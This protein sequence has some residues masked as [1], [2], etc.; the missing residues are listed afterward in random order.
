MAEGRSRRRGVVRSSLALLP[1]AICEMSWTH[2]GRAVC[3][4]L[5]PGPTAGVPGATMPPGRVSPQPPHFCCSTTSQ[6]Q[7]VQ[8]NQGSWPPVTG[9]HGSGAGGGPGTMRSAPLIRRGAVPFLLSTQ[10]LKL[11]FLLVFCWDSSLIFPSYF[12]S[13]HPGGRRFCLTTV[14]DI[15]LEYP[16]AGT[17]LG[18]IRTYLTWGTLGTSMRRSTLV[19][20]EPERPK[21][22]SEKQEHQDQEGRR[23]PGRFR[24]CQHPSGRDTHSVASKVLLGCPLALEAQAGGLNDDASGTWNTPGT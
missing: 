22:R 15:L 7:Y 8:M 17:T 20:S 11:V 21:S 13:I 10:C 16:Q 6:G 4:V 9:W 3:T 14:S 12:L 5:D 2:R 1:P 18:P 24:V 19:L 23:P